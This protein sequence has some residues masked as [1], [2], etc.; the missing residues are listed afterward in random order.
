MKAVRCLRIT[1]LGLLCSR[2]LKSHYSGDQLGPVTVTPV[3]FGPSCS[4]MSLTK[5]FSIRSLPYHEPWT[6][7]SWTSK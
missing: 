4:N 6:S 1:E 3:E 5:V 2:M 7:S